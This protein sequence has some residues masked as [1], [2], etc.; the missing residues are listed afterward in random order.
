LL[1]YDDLRKENNA[2]NLELAFSVADQHLGI[3]RLLDVEDLKDPDEKSVMT[4]VSEY[5]HK[6]AEYEKT[7]QFTARVKRFLQLAQNLQQLKSFYTN[8]SPVFVDWLSAKIAQ[9]GDL[10]FENSL[11]TVKSQLFKFADY[12][13]NEKTRKIA[14][15]F[16]LTGKHQNLQA[17]LTANQMPAYH[18]PAGADPATI[19]KLWAELEEIEKARGA[20]LN[21][22]MKEHLQK[23]FKTFDKEGTG[24]LNQAQ[25]KGCLQAVGEKLSD[26]ELEALFNL[27]PADDVGQRYLDFGHFEK[28]F[29]SLF[30]S[31]D[32]PDDI[33]RGFRFVSNNK[34]YSLPDDLK[35]L[36]LE[37]D[38]F[39]WS[40]QHMPGKSGGFDYE[41]F[42]DSH[43][44]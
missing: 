15:K 41:T 14:E 39:Q 38:L 13:A 9:L 21:T 33:K 29:L 16:E 4:Y 44:K 2:H 36:A 3:P 8:N 6:L 28:F 31:V 40:T 30:S 25:F 12:Q 1:N 11:D 34:D 17:L 18:P 22:Q 35:K 26:A 43:W 19:E 5:Y 42:T 23:L 27:Q 7:L 32:S 10:N 37:N 20:K 24:K